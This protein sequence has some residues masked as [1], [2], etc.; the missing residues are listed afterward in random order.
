[1][2]TEMTS[3]EAR[4]NI[5]YGGA[6]GDL[7]DTVSFDAADGDVKQW[8]TEA[9]RG[10]GVPG[11]ALDANADFTDFVVDRFTANVT[12]P[13][14][15]IQLRPKTPFGARA[16]MCYFIPSDGY[17]VKL[18]FRVSVVREDEGGHH[19]SGGWPYD[20]K[21]HGADMPEAVRPWFWG[22]TFWDAEEIAA[23]TNAERLGLSAV[24]VTE[25][26]LA[27][28]GDGVKE[29]GGRPIP[30][31][32]DTHFVVDDIDVAELT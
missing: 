3:T 4:V 17:V 28:M 30:E 6:N 21:D 2:T 1:M 20:G 14:N 31:H 18:G 29:T 19:P 22:H 12:R 11:I 16:R 9:V 26:M 25:I 13:Y 32:P 15:L 10:G 7:P 24:D 27:S 5:T 23:K 8:V